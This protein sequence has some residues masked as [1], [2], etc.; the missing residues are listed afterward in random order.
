MQI[1]TDSRYL[2]FPERS[3]VREVLGLNLPVAAAEDV[4]SGKI[5]AAQ[6]PHRRPG[7]RPKDLLD[8]EQLVEAHPEISGRVP[9]DIIV[10]LS[11]LLTPLNTLAPSHASAR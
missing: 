8:I 11:R 1:Q 7:K 4:L 5:W 3:V 10:K 9:S 2:H 6:D